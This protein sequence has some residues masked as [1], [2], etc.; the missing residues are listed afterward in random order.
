MSETE[1]L[2]TAGTHPKTW[3]VGASCDSCQ[4]A[5]AQ[6]RA[7]VWRG[8]PL[9]GIVPGASKDTPEVQWRRD[10]DPGLDAYLTARKEGIQPDQSDLKSVDAAHKRIK[11]QEAAL[12][13]I[14]KFSD[15]DGIKTTA[16]V[17][18]DVK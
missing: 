6:A 15:I 16:G 10:F 5:S 11:S 9:I 2:G 4:T 12:R 8:S 18:R 14:K 13:A 3:K 1:H 7:D 17:D